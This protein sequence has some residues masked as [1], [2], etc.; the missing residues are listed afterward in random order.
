LAKVYG[1]SHANSI[2]LR[3]NCMEFFINLT[4]VSSMSNTIAEFFVACNAMPIMF[5]NTAG[6]TKIK[7]KQMTSRLQKII[8][9]SAIL[10]YYLLSISSHTSF[11]PI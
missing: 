9:P 4:E 6:K 10:L 3:R 2:K 7:R 11:R 5:C 1:A 8:L